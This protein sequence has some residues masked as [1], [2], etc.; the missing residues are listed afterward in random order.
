MRHA[1]GIDIGGINTKIG[2]VREGP[3]FKVL[4]QTSIPTQVDDPISVYVRRVAEAVAGLLK[5]CGLKKVNGAGVGCPGLIDPWKGLVR[6]SPNL[7]NLKGVRLAD[8]LSGALNLPVRMQNDANAAALGE[9]L[10]GSGKKCPNLIVLT[11][12]TGVGGGVICDGHLVVGADN[13]ATELG[14]L[15]AEWHNGAPCG[16]GKTGCVEAYVGAA[17]ITRIAREMLDGGASTILQPDHLTPRDV[18]DAARKGDK[19]ALEVMKKV[20][21]YLGRGIALL[22][23]TFNPERIVFTGGTSAAADLMM[24]GIDDALNQYASF[25]FTRKRVKISRSKFPDDVNVIGAA[26]VYLNAG[27]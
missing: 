25:E 9:Y 8:K 14:H 19:T 17:G 15:K 3:P 24:P 23:E 26:A 10:F 16:C 5:E 1:I 7:P 27:K 6:T 22:I 21:H 4:K 11:L 12:G 2:I 18:A 13:A 20:G